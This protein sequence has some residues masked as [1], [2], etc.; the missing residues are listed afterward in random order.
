MKMDFLNIWKILLERLFIRFFFLEF[1]FFLNEFEQTHSNEPYKQKSIEDIGK[2]VDTLNEERSEKLNR[3]KIVEKEK[4]GLES[5]RAEAID[6]L[7][8]ENYLVLERAKLFQ[9]AVHESK[10]GATETEENLVFF[11]FFFFFFFCLNNH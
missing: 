2:K 5:K 1:F 4:D 11:F 9:V 8:K 6:Y 10:I 7:K 3:V